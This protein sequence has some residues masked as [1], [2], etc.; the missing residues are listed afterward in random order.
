MWRCG[1]SMVVGGDT[2]NIRVQAAGALLLSTGVW[3]PETDPNHTS[4]GSLIYRLCGKFSN[5][6]PSRCW[7]IWVKPKKNIQAPE[8][9]DTESKL[10]VEE[11][12]GTE[13]WNPRRVHRGLRG[14]IL[15]TMTT[16]RCATL[17]TQT[18]Q[19]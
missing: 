16:R 6:A 10:L 19:K 4:S 12:I 1:S 18:L 8:G 7:D 13:A 14:D 17:Q 15:I 5:L 9:G 2:S 3:R 11:R